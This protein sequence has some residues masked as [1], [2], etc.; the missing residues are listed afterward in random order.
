MWAT[1][2]SSDALT[3]ELDLRPYSSSTLQADIASLL[4]SVPSDA[5][6]VLVP[7]YGSAATKLFIDAVP[8]DTQM[9]IM[10]WGGASDSIFSSNCVGKHCFGTFTVGSKY[11]TLGLQAVLSKASKPLTVGLIKNDDAFSASVAAGA[12]SYISSMDGLTLGKEITVTKGALSENDLQEVSSI[13]AMKPDVIAVAGHSGG[14]VETVI[15]EIKKSYV[16]SA[17]VATNSITSTAQA[18]LT[19][20][21]YADAS[22]CLLMPTQWGYSDTA[23][24]YLGWTS[25]AFMTAFGPDA[26]YHA[27]S[28]A[29]AGI[30]ISGAIAAMGSSETLAS[31]LAKIDFNSFYGKL[32]FSQDGSIDKPMYIQQKHTDTTPVF[33]TMF[34]DLAYPLAACTGWGGAKTCSQ[35]K[36]FYK[37]MKCCGV[38]A[39]TVDTSSLTSYGQR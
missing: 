12:V 2:Y 36:A 4:S 22:Q 9:P 34:G 10:V 18:R 25:D 23:D 38:P 16:P 35:V 8:A 39:K 21:G 6:G 37:D 14:D 33:T 19:E 27:A 32:K 11:M 15:A 3:V 17:I 5:S 1:S 28:A 31:A 29:A 24:P 26:S 7:P 13:I 20:M 30:A